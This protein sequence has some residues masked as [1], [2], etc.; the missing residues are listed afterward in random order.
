MPQLFDG[1][2]RF[3]GT[4]RDYQ[5]RVLDHAPRYLADG[6]LH[7]VAAPGSGKTTLG[8]E[9]IRR[10]GKPC[11][12]LSPSI[13][14]RQQWL[15]RI[16]QGFL[17]EG[18]DPQT[19]LSHDLR[20]IR[21]IT[22]I[23]YQALYSAMKQLQGRLEDGG[24]EDDQAP[25]EGEAVDF[26]DFRIFEAVKRAGV[27]TI[28]LDEAHHL[29]S[30]WWKALEAFVK[31]AG[32]VT[33]I[34][35][36]A[37]PPYD[38]TPAQWKRYTDLCGPIDEEI[39]TP[40]LVREGSLCPHEDY[41][42]FNWPTQQE[43]SA[44]QAHHQRVGQL[45]AWLMADERLM[46]GV[47][48]HPGLQRPQD[49]SQVFL[50]QPKYFSALLMYCQAQGIP[51]SRELKEL[52]GIRG[53]LPPLNDEYLA[54]LIQGMLFDDAQSYTLPAD[55]RGY[56]VEAL[57]TAGCLHRN[58]V[59]LTL[60]E[61]LQKQLMKSQGKLRSIGHIA[62]GEYEALGENLRLL[63]LCDYIRQEMLPLV[64]TDGALHGELG[65]VPIF[66]RLRR[67][68][69]PGLRLGC[70]S[71][72]VVLLP[73]DTGEEVERMLEQRGCSGT[74]RPLGD[75]GYGRWMGKAATGHVV[76]VVT[77]LLE[78][79]RIQAL[80]GTKSLLGEGWD[81]PCVNTL[82]LATYVGSFMLSNQMRGR[83]I[84]TDP[85]HP[86]KTGNIWH[87]ACVYQERDPHTGET[88]FAGDYPTLERRFNAFLGVS[89]RENLI[90]SGIQRL[91]LP[92]VDRPDQVDV[93]NG[94][95]LCRAADRPGL[96]QRWLDALGEVHGEMEIQRTREVPRAHI[97]TGYVFYHALGMEGLALA[98]VFLAVL[99]QAAGGGVEGLAGGAVAAA[100]L[101][102]RYGPRLLR[103]S[104]PLR[105]MRG[106]GKGVVAALAR[107]GELD[108]PAHCRAAVEPLG[109][110]AVR[111]WLE[112]GSM[113]DKANYD[114]CMEQLWGVI[115]NPRYLLAPRHGDGREVY[116]V[117]EIFGRQKERAAVLEREMQRVLGPSFHLIYTRTPQ[118][119]RALLRART[120]SFVNRNQQVWQGRKVVKGTYE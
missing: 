90:E 26:H 40:E 38:S 113:R 1:V 51:F 89:W 18:N 23:T 119:R 92:P 84:R 43:V 86:D 91:D 36:T 109:D 19:L 116:A 16:T 82:I 54:A 34:S 15:E 79:G 32:D 94:T 120:Q 62:A 100:L 101:T 17:V 49:Y 99:Y 2:L 27:G 65:A 56:L 52:L 9:L 72:S 77:Q 47:A 73:M 104:T 24:E 59:R 78:Q 41:V 81:A 114:A 33:V 55:Y 70:L 5:Q 12:I 30:E 66:E 48:S 37:T 87:L 93:V 115:D 57:K 96:R 80:V 42:Y 76:A 13:A 97:P 28:C 46:Q 106:L 44:I 61:A 110:A 102:A 98:L 29:R 35:L 67:M 53:P 111:T 63:V 4:W 21:P 31:G 88:Y 118:G 108:D 85:H 69:L 71:G 107:L 117:P 83:T 10:L 103:T 14:I 74:L 6:K 8:I 11:L 95:M 20:D 68:A 25:G 39:F 64:G 3:K 75:T 112:G 58:T 45:R 105:R 7:I 50:D 60:D 22:A